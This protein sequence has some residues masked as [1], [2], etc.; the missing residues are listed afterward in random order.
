MVMSPVNLKA[1][2]KMKMRD[3]VLITGGT[4]KNV[5]EYGKIECIGD[6]LVFVKMESHDIVLPFL[7]KMLPYNK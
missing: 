3:K 4:G 7:K 1:R 5:G 6:E 2:N